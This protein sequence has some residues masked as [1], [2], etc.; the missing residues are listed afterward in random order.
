MLRRK[1]W[2][3]WL[4]ALIA[5]LQI[6]IFA[7]YVGK[8]FVK[9]DFTWL[10]NVVPDGKV[11]YLRSFTQTTGFFRP[12]VG[13]SF[14]VQ[15]Q[16]YGMNPRPYGLFNLF[17]H[18]FNIIL[19]YLLLSSW[20]K[21]RSSAIWIAALFALN[22][23]GVNMAVGWISGRTTLLFSFFMLLTLIVYLRLPKKS[24]I[25]F[26]LISI[27]YFA[28]LLSKEEAVVAPLFIFLLAFF[29]GGEDTGK[30]GVLRRFKDGFGSVVVFILPLIVYVLLRF[31]SNAMT[32]FNA[33]DYYKYSFSPLLLLDN[34]IEY[35]N[36]TGLLDF[37]F[38]GAL[39]LFVFVFSV[40][41]KKKARR[42]E[43]FNRREFYWGLVWFLCFLLPSLPL[44]ARSSLYIY[45]PQIGL[46]VSVFVAMV[47]L[48]GKLVFT[49]PS[50]RYA[51]LIFACLLLLG[52]VRYLYLKSVSIGERGEISARFS[53]QVVQAVSEIPPWSRVFIIDT[54]FAEKQSPTDIIAYGFNSLLHLYYPDKH[55]GGEI[56]SPAE[57]P[58]IRR[59]PANFIFIW[60]NGNL[61]NV[62]W[63]M[64]LADIKSFRLF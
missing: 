24:A 29:F 34:L 45:F 28:A 60:K 15:Y 23:K 19:V 12:L 47:F 61:N 59:D 33:P 20:E 51:V 38:L 39:L 37:Y 8:G 53:G 11:D 64:H 58:R 43:R 13:F 16:V 10:E 5:T 7:P 62:P 50:Q 3:L 42:E 26:L 41:L 9:D 2:P 54:H 14:G 46:H 40:L 1:K 22:S 63:L 31:Q 30:M 44:P 52:W 27:F 17:L 32:P 21:T 56:V 49:K 18:V 55:I 6:L 25:R 48:W 36:R 57:L 35:I 4:L